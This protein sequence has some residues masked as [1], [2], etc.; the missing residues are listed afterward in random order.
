[1]LL[2][3]LAAVPESLDDFLAWRPCSYREHFAA[4]N[5]K[6]RETVI[7]AYR[8]SDPAIRKALDALADTMNV[9]LLATREAMKA[10]TTASSADA[11]ANCA[12]AWLRPLVARAGYVIN[13]T[14]AV[15]ARKADAG[16]AQAAVD[17]LMQR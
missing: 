11:L 16:A 7:A 4:S 3:M 14:D 9:M 6:N 5:F 2:E 10:S 8:E 1:M 13:G 17:A 15:K 12:V